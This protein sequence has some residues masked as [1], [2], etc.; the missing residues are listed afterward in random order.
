[1][2]DWR[3][4]V[5]KDL[6]KAILD[7]P[8]L[9]MGQAIAKEQAEISFKAGYQQALR[10]I[11]KRGFKAGIKEVVEW[12]V[13]HKKGEFILT[14][15]ELSHISTFQWTELEWQDFLKEWGIK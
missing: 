13:A 14:D 2:S 4:T 12:V 1:M 5:M 7:N 6:S 3:D 9:P 10:D 8:D 11:K 15:G